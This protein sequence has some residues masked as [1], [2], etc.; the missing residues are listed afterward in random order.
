MNAPPR[1]VNEAAQDFLKA[2]NGEEDEDESDDDSA[3]D[4]AAQVA[5]RLVYCSA[6]HLTWVVL[7]Q[8]RS[9]PRPCPAATIRHEHT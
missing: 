3:D 1:D 7:D 6:P 2:A 9:C 4:N 8:P 5:V